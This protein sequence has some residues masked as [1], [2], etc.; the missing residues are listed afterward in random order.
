LFGSPA[1]FS[2]FETRHRT[3]NCFSV[4]G[5]KIGPRELLSHHGDYRVMCVTRSKRELGDSR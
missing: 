5:G 2:N 1:I 3:L 4:V